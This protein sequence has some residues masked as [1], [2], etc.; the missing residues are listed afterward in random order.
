MSLFWTCLFGVN[1]NENFKVVDFSIPTPGQYSP[2]SIIVPFV[3]N[4]GLVI[5]KARVDQMEGNF[6]I[7]TGASGLILNERYFTPDQHLADLQGL[8]LGGNTAP[9]GGVRL[10]SF[11]LEEL[12]FQQTKAQTLDLS[13]IEHS[14]KTRILGLIGYSILKDFEILFDYRQR[15][16]TFSE[17]DQDG[18]VLS[19]LPHT[20]HKA[21]SL[22]F[23]FGNFI[24]L[25][26]V[27][28]NNKV[29]WMG[30]D[31]GA[32]YNLLNVKRCKDILSVFSI[33]KTISIANP[34]RKKVEAL[35]G[36]LSRMI[37]KDKYRCGA[38]STVLT[39]LKDLETVYE[40]KLDGILGYDFFATW[41]VSINYKKQQLYLHHFNSNS[42]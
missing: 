36:K 30:M 27:K 14:K 9:V 35:V 19:P 28:V 15:I 41:L 39:N 7:D 3:F 4:G 2:N 22:S 38:M 5:V 10:D 12:T 29:K 37:L 42:P 17:T 8:S 6:I 40:C 13:S 23:R 24:P 1:P 11:A 32:E 33:K 21:D 26:E 16:L 20:L 18:N 34:G 31:T 25:I